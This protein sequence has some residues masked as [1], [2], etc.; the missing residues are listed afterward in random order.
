M[1]RV[2]VLDPITTMNFVLSVVIVALAIL[3]YTSKK[4]AIA[5]YIGIAFAFFGISHFMNLVGAPGMT[6]VL[7]IIRTIA[8]LTVLF[9]LFKTWKS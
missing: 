9:A 7:L 4:T 1:V 3:V 2:F 8:Y 5:L 6:D